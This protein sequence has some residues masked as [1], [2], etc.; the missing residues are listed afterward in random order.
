MPNAPIARTALEAAEVAGAA[1]APVEPESELDAALPAD[2]P[3]WQRDL[4]SISA[5]TR[6]ILA[7]IVPVTVRILTFWDHRLREI[8]VGGRRLG[9]DPSGCYRLR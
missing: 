1:L 7:T 9:V 5:R 6:A 4:V 8:A 3:R 2:H